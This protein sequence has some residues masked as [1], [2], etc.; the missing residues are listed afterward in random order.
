MSVTKMFGAEAFPEVSTGT[1]LVTS[2]SNAMM[3][4]NGPGTL[5]RMSPMESVQEL[6]V[7]MANSLQ[8]IVEN[9]T[10]TNELLKGTDAERRDA[11]LDKTDTDKDGDKKPEGRS[12]ADRLKSLNPFK[13]GLGSNLPTFIL[14]LGAL[15]GLKLFGDELLPSIAGL[16]ESIS[17]GKIGQRVKD[18]LINF[19]EGFTYVLDFFEGIG[20]Y[21]NEFDVDDEKGLSP[22]EFDNLKK[23]IKKRTVDLIS[24]FIGDVFNTLK[25]SILST[26][27]LGATVKSLLGNAA[28]KN[29]FSPVS[30]GFIGPRAPVPGIGLAGGLGIA[31][32]IGYGIIATYTNASNAITKSMKDGD[33]GMGS[34]IA[35]FLGGKGEGG[36]FNAMKQGLLVAG[37]GALAGAAL[38]LKFGVAG[39]AVGGPAGM[40]AGALIGFAVGGIIGVIGGSVG[41]DAIKGMMDNVGTAITE[42]MDSIE[43]FV[44]DA[45]ENVRKIFTGRL[46]S[47][48]TDPVRLNKELAEAKDELTELQNKPDTAVNRNKIKKKKEEIEDIKTLLSLLTPEMIEKAKQDNANDMTRNEDNRIDRAEGKMITAQAKV[49]ELLAMTPEERENEFYF[50]TQLQTARNSYANAEK[51]FKKAQMD[52]K[53]IL[54]DLDIDYEIPAATNRI[55]DTMRNIDMR[56]P[57]AMGGAKS[58][59]IANNNNDNSTKSFHETYVNSG[60]SVANPNHN[61]GYLIARYGRT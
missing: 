4:T 39:F 53:N 19:K 41:S 40:I 29:I 21:I 8:A 42:M 24:G 57:N 54:T 37:T 6:F 2:S 20:D 27:F 26:L 14:A 17:T 61:A 46:T 38:G 7:S 55:V 9:T 43:T 44:M 49:N 45:F 5:S 18:A 10:Q 30:K 11:S 13:E 22:E 3:T 59:V 1:D 33:S 23:D 51:N 58:A 60:L 52:K 12:F 28:I 36:F 16:L 31:A 34:F 32:L 25:F 56:Q 35:N 15:L 50:E 48:E 47:R